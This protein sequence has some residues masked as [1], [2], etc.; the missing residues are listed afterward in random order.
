[1]NL[2]NLFLFFLLFR[3]LTGVFKSGFN[4]EPGKNPRL[5]RIPAGDDQKKKQK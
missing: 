4:A 2:F 3:H 1:V 5:K